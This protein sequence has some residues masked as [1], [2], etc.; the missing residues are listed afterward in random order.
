MR[1]MDNVLD[2]YWTIGYAFSY[3]SSLTPDVST[4]VY[5]DWIPLQIKIYKVRQFLLKYNMGGRGIW[6]VNL[7]ITDILC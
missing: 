6:C 7:E 1:S 2:M 5:L 4:A 3:D